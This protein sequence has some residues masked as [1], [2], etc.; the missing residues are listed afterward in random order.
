MIVPTPN[1]SQF[2]VTPN[3]AFPLASK[4]ADEHSEPHGPAGKPPSMESSDSLEISPYEAS[5]DDDKE[6][7][8]PYHGRELSDNEWSRADLEESSPLGMSMCPSNL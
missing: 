2:C 7:S 1:T 8:E 6:S 5:Y 4:H 3:A